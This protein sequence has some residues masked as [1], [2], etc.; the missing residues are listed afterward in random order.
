MRALLL[1]LLC[2]CSCNLQAWA[3]DTATPAL[4]TRSCATTEYQ[5]ALQAQDPSLVLRQQQA[6]ERAQEGSFK[7]SQSKAAWRNTIITIPVVFHVV[8]NTE[9]E[10]I[11][12]EQILSQLAI[13]NADFRRQNPDT[14]NTPAYFRPFAADTQIE[15]CL[16]SIDPNGDPTTGITRT[17]TDRA[18]FETSRDD[19][20]FTSRGGKDIWDSNQY[21]NIWVCR[22]TG[23]TLGYSSFPGYN[24]NIDG[25]V[26]LYSSVGA[27]PFNRSSGPYNQGR[28]ATH[29]VGHWLGLRHIW[30]SACN[31]ADGIED[32][33]NQQRDTGGCPTGIV[34]SCNNGPYGNMWQNY[35]DYTDDGCMNLFTNGQ[36]ALMQATLATA[37]PSILSSLACT[38]RI[39]SDFEIT[40]PTDTLVLVGTAVNFTDKSEGSRPTAWLWEFEGGTPATSTEQNPTV[41]YNTPGS[42]TVKLT[43]TN[44]IVSDTA[45]KLQ[46][47]EVTVSD[48]VVYPNPAAAYITI[49]QPARIEVR[50][51]E[52]VNS[53]GQTVLQQTVADRVVQ[54]QV[55]HLP[56]G[57][58]YLRLQSSNGMVI[59]KI[60]VIR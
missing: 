26:L 21:L 56:A 22:I 41:T 18:S 50:H 31:N 53:I 43:V 39:R 2:I 13:L 28:T 9:A 6:M 33:P 30:G 10:N 19:V 55:Q 17:Q 3:Q 11:P 38:G 8:Y 7:L 16:A 42:Y 32:T 1:V 15:F 25:V 14:V 49:E 34:T 57:V 20:K 44:G 23:N 59:K 51:I 5:E 35:M 52:L 48:L 46:Y 60:S 58:Y 4:H 36:A 12:D 40:N 47:I 45:E 29:E 27:P 37:R 24:A 54:L